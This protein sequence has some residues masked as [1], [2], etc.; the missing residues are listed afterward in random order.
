MLKITKF[1][2]S[3]LADASR[4]LRVRDIVLCDVSRRVVVVSA[5]GKRHAGDHKVTD[6][7]YLCHAHLSYGVSCWDLWRRISDRYID[8]RNGCALQYPIEQELERIYSG[9]SAKTGRDYIAS[10]GEY[11][12]ALLMAELL[13]F[14]F[15]D[16]ADWLQF[17]YAGH[18]LTDESYAKL[19]SLADG[20]KI[21]TPGFYGALPNGAIRTF[22]RGGS[23]VTGSL[24]A[25]ALHADLYEN[26]TDVTGILAADPRIVQNPASIAQLS[27]EELQALSQV[28]TQVLHESAVEP[29]RRRQIPLQIRNTCQP[30]LPGTRIGFQHTDCALEPAIVGLA[31]RRQMAMLHV[32]APGLAAQSGEILQALARAQLRV[33]HSACG[34][35]QLTVL[36]DAGN[37]A[38][39]LHECAERLRAR[40]PQAQLKL[41]ENLSVLAALLRGSALLPKLLAAVEASGAPVHYLAEA[42]PCALMIVNDSQYETALRAAYAVCQKSG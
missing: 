23:D 34:L 11:L 41:R 36:I 6:L 2:G 7:L 38:E 13:G 5:A 22:S 42:R 28:G 30:E 40:F 4:F 27:Y 16:S 26:W 19:Q 18:V 39:Q 9:L 33:F 25:A 32:A 31:G 12:S 35:D 8:I 3:S 21:V 14:T 37:G 17:D 15:V 1:G 24:A 29:V 20:R 10:R